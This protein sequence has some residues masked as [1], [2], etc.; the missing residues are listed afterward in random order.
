MSEKYSKQLNFIKNTANICKQ[1]RQASLTKNLKGGSPYEKASAFFSSTI[2]PLA[3][4]K[5]NST[6]ENS[7]NAVVQTD[8]EF[9]I[10][11]KLKKAQLQMNED[12]LK[13][14]IQTEYDMNKVNELRSGM[15]FSKDFKGIKKW[16]FC[17]VVTNIYLMLTVAFKGALDYPFP[18]YFEDLLHSNQNLNEQ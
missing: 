15:R 12:K 5:S 14:Q 11:E 10:Y 6:G 1:F 9:N 16:S 13:K 4:L 3:E 7:K 17:L 2:T 18:G 8:Q